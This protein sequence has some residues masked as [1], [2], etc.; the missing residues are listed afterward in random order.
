[1]SDA[2]APSAPPPAANRVPYCIQYT[3]VC[4][5]PAAGLSGLSR[6]LFYSRYVSRLD[7][8]NEQ[9]ERESFPI[10]LEQ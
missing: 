5:V 6:E 10:P 3:V 7:D 1:M 8:D 4:R 9:A 2:L